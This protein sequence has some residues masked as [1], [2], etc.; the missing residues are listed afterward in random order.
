[1]FVNLALQPFLR[2]VNTGRQNRLNILHGG[3]IASM[4]MSKKA[5]LPVSTTTNGLMITSRPWWLAGSCF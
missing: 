3:T 5:L 4:G 1:M 2:T